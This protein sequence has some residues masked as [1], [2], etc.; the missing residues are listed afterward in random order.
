MAADGQ[1]GLSATAWRTEGSL[2]VATRFAST[3]SEAHRFA[4]RR[5]LRFASCEPARCSNRADG[6]C[7][8]S[9]R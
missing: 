1:F 5:L 7:G 3:R 8:I 4:L 9:E 6:Q 2:W